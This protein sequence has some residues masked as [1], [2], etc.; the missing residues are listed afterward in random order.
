MIHTG[1]RQFGRG[2]RS[3]RSLLPAGVSRCDGRGDPRSRWVLGGTVNQTSTKGRP[4]ITQDSEAVDLCVAD[5]SRWPNRDHA[6]CRCQWV[7]V[8]A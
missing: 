4:A 1:C 2:Q 6:D 3:R 5:A 7:P 8:A